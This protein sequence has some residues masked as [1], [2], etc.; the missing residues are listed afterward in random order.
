MQKKKIDNPKEKIVVEISNSLQEAFDILGAYQFEV[1]PCP[2][3]VK[4]FL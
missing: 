1:P 3:P 4:K 2:E